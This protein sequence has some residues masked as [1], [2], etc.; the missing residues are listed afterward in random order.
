MM[1]KDL[2]GDGIIDYGNNR[3]STMGDRTVIGNSQPR[4][5]YNFRI[6]AAWKGFDFDVFFQG[7]GKRSIA[8]TGNMVQPGHTSSE[9]NFAHTLDYWTVDNTDAFYPRPGT[10][11]ETC[12]RYL[13]NMAYLRCKTLTLGYTLPRQI[14]QKI[15]INR[16]RAYVTGENLF[17]FDKLGK[18][19]F[20]PEMNW[21]STTENDSRSFGRSYPYRRTL[22]FGIQVEF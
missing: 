8:A 17:E 14:S 4:Y 20:D 16:L 13:L 21:T 3:L 19:A 22:S 15:M 7:V 2:N 6:G 1:Y 5:L 9:A 18:I 12:D 11:Y 10:S